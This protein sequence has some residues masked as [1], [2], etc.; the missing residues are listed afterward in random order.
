[1]LR[2]GAAVLYIDQNTV[3]APWGDQVASLRTTTFS[4]R[5][6]WFE[7]RAKVATGAGLAGVVSAFWLTPPGVDYSRS[8]D[9]GGRR[10]LVEPFEIDVFEQF[11]QEPNGN[12][13]TVHAGNDPYF[14][15]ATT[16]GPEGA[17]Y[18][19]MH[20]EEFGRG[21]FPSVLSA[22]FHTYAMLWTLTGMTWFFD[23][24]E[25][26]TLSPAASDPFLVR[27]T[28]YRHPSADPNLRHPGVRGRL[29]SRLRFPVT[30]RVLRACCHPEKGGC[31]SR[32]EF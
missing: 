22:D 11:T 15:G 4:Q 29:R 18:L 23:G 28:L 17:D 30:G 7:I 12:T 10:P 9:Q 16:A 32:C 1:L 5:Y 8:V 27:L 6:G 14:V 21:T 25:Y 2:D 3:R 24:Q 19:T 26:G 31:G 20:R 13:W